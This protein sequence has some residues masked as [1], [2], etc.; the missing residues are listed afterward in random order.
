M[1]INNLL[2]V[3]NLKICENNH[4]NSYTRHAAWQQKSRKTKKTLLN[5]PS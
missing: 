2:F 4:N 3:N 1:K 5:N